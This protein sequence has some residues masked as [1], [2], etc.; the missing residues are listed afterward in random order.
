MG[1]KAENLLGVLDRTGAGTSD[2]VLRRWAAD[3]PHR[4]FTALALARAAVSLSAGV[5]GAAL[6][7]ALTDFTQRFEQLESQEKLTCPTA[8]LTGK[9]VIAELGTVPGP[10]VGEALRFLEEVR[11]EEGPLSPEA[12][13]FRLSEWYGREAKTL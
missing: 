6:A 4:S 2:A 12:A 9:D 8:P 11:I 3:A 1:R 13:R 7:E 10:L 5:D